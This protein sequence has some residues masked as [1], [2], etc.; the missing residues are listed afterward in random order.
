MKQNPTTGAFIFCGG[1][2][3][4]AYRWLWTCLLDLTWYRV[5]EVCLRIIFKRPPKWVGYRKSKYYIQQS[6]MEL[7]RMEDCKVS[8]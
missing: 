8:K 4:D 3:D 6:Y 1:E 7:K 2:Q 5:I